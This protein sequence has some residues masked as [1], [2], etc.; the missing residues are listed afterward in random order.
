ML[1]GSFTGTRDTDA[2]NPHENLMEQYIEDKM[3]AKKVISNV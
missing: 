3:G 1:G 2:E